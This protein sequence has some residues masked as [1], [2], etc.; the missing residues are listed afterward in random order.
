MWCALGEASVETPSVQK[1][2][3]IDLGTTYSALAVLQDG[4][5]EI[6]VNAQGQRTTPSVV[7]FTKDGEVIVGALAKEKALIDPQNTVY[8]VKR[9]MGKT[10]AEAADETQRVPYQITSGPQG[11][12]NVAVPN[13]AKSLTPEEISAFIL[14]DLKKSA[15][16]F[17]GVPV[18]EAVITV[19]AYFTNAQRQATKDA[20]AI[21]GL[22]VE[23]IINEPTSAA[24]AYGLSKSDAQTVLV[25]D[26]GGGTFDVSVLK[27]SEGTYQVLA[28]SGDN[29]LGGDDIDALIV[30]WIAA[31]TEKKTGIDPLKEP[32][33]VQ[34]LKDASEKAKKEL[35]TAQKTTISLPYLVAGPQGPT[36]IELTLDRIRFGAMLQPILARLRGPT[37][38]ALKDSKLNWG[39]IDEVVLV[40]GSCRIPAV[41]SLVTSM[42]GKEPNRTMNYDEAV[43]LGAAV[44]AG[45]IGGDEIAGAAGGDIVLLDLTPF[46]LG[47]ELSGGRMSRLIEKNTTIPTR[48]K[49]T[50]TTAADNQTAVTINILQG[51]SQ[52]SAENKSLGKF[53]LDGIPPAPSGVPQIEITFEIDAN[54]IVLVTAKDLNT[55]R[56]Q[57]ITITGSVRMSET[58]RNQA[59]KTVQALHSA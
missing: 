46:S 29:H 24:L 1:I 22:K 52:S 51:E 28:T 5:P 11:R 57:N 31:E 50:Y 55:G 26:F 47:V 17:L 33:A 42:T 23:K 10:I 32:K 2:I 38:T 13:V 40:G 54:G 34:R 44:E 12:A 8:S 7:H 30:K 18:A 39:K 27:F 25:F 3:G 14:L 58:E 35:S 4:K 59:A 36:D 43:A 53:K 45:V 49:D 21:A 16:A 19:P 41:Q 9:L 20:G 6:I 56:Q 48:K 15:E 37:E